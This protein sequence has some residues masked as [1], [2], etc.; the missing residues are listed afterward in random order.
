MK[1]NE[2]KLLIQLI[3]INASKDA[4]VDGLEVFKN[5]KRY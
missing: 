1:G 5:V 2:H 4:E 3:A